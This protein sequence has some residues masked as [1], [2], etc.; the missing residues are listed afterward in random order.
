MLFHVI[1]QLLLWAYFFD[2]TPVQ[3]NAWSMTGF[4]NTPISIKVALGIVLW[5][6]KAIVWWS[7]KQSIA[8]YSAFQWLNPKA[9]FIEIGA[10]HCSLLAKWATLLYYSKADDVVWLF[11]QCRVV[12]WKFMLFLLCTGVYACSV[13]LY[14]CN[15][16]YKHKH[17][18]SSP[19]MS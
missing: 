10:Y 16:N 6:L 15:I 11:P 18:Q 19:K 9:T 13:L 3:L 14:M 4:S 17:V 12:M 2:Y 8:L 1:L 7:L 5:S